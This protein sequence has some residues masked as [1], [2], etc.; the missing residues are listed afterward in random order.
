MEVK[1]EGYETRMITLDKEFNVISIFNLGNLL[2]W[3]IE[4][5]SGAMMNLTGKRMTL[6]YLPKR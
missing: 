3:G 4:A 6:I 1:L 5:V 2:A